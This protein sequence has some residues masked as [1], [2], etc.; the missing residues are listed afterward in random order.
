MDF[1]TLSCLDGG[2][3]LPKFL[4][5]FLP[6]EKRLVRQFVDSFFCLL[7]ELVQSETSLDDC[8]FLHQEL[9]V[10]VRY[11]CLMRSP[12]LL[13]DCGGQDRSLLALEHHA[14]DF[15]P[16]SYFIFVDNAVIQVFFWRLFQVHLGTC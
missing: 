3:L 10:S 16:R 5:H 14:G 6:Y 8:G 1:D 7:L 13:D 4:H 15:Y 11:S 12:I 9:Q 2:P